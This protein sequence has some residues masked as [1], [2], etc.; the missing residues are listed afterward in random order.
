MKKLMSYASATTIKTENAISAVATKTAYKYGHEWLRQCKD[1]VYGN[2]AYIKE[3]LALNAPEIVPAELEGT[4]LI[5]LDCRE[6]TSMGVD[7]ETFFEKS[8]KIAGDSGKK[9]GEMWTEF[10][11]LNIATRRVNI[12]EAMNR[13]L[14]AYQGIDR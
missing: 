8:A 7:I 4:F 3:F 13:L 12:E 11:R 9:F 1:Y 10:Y 2:Y 5:W 6:L 14:K